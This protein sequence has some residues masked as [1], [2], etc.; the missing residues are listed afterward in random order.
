[1]NSMKRK[2]LAVMLGAVMTASMTVNSVSF[3]ENTAAKAAADAAE[4]T[5]E[6]AAADTAEDTSES[7]SE[8]GSGAVQEEDTIYGEVTAVDDTSITIDV[9]TLS[10]NAEEQSAQAPQKPSGKGGMGAPGGQ[11]GPG[12]SDNSSVNY[13]AAHEYSGSTDISGEDLTSTGVDEN[14]V[15][16][17][18]PDAEVSI[19]DSTIRRDSGN[20]TGGDNSSF[21]GV[22]AAALAT[23]GTLYIDDSAITTDAKGGAGAFAYGDGKVY[24]ADTTINTNQDTSG[25][26]HVAGGGTLYAWDLD[27]TTNG[28]SSAA[29]RSDRGS[30]TEV[31]DGGTYTSN[32][33]GSPAIYSTADITVNDADLTANGS[34]A[35]CIEGLNTIR[36]FDCDLTGNMPDQD[37]NDTT[38]NV[39]VYQSMSGDSEEGNGTFEM[40]GGTLT[41]KNGGMFYTTNTQSTI[42][43]KDVDITYSDDNPF[44]LQCTGNANQRGWGEAGNNGADCLFTAI[45]QDMEGNVIWDSISDLD[46]YITDA[47]SL[48]GAF[49]NDETYAGNG[50][51]GYAN[52]YIDS[53]STWTVTGDSTVTSLFNEGKIAD[54]EGNTV[55]VIGTDGTVYVKGDSDYTITVASYSD[56]ADMSGAS[57]VSVYSDYAVEKPSQFE[58][59]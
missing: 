50:G 44:F 54:E 31:I 56:S 14:A 8:N 38:W 2:Y 18:G 46:F 6:E 15:L 59:A 27:V 33:A 40:T 58:E 12:A 42:T 3:A 11:G 29:I 7:T 35:I 17:D 22:G 20:S 57:S 26:V 55:S 13:S 19:S 28:E 39:I 30:G 43:L 52:V 5:A 4:D 49:V 36:L 10:R 37:Q 47:S 51:E 45:Q 23:D 34:E 41:A 53:T 16:A 32:G 1:M 24:I 25:G 48:T 9:G 21:Y